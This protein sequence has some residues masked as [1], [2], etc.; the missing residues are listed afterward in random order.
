MRRYAVELARNAAL[1][2]GGL[3]GFVLLMFVL[4]GAFLGFDKDALIVM[5]AC[6]TGC[7]VAYGV[8]MVRAIPFVRMIRRQEEEGLALEDHVLLLHRG[9]TGTYLGKSWLIHAGHAAFHHSKI[10]SVQRLYRSRGAAG[11]MHYICVTTIEGRTYR[12]PMSTQSRS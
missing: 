12:W 8:V 7:L 4:C 11:R 2:I 6:F 10:H 1:L 9:L 3:A 5:A